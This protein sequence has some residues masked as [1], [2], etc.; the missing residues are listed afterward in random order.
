M[1]TAGTSKATAVVKDRAEDISFIGTTLGPLFLEDPST[2]SAEALFR[3]FSELDV[4]DAAKSWPFVEAGE[5]CKA[6][7]MM[8]NA[9]ADGLTDDLTWAFRQLFVGPMPK[10]AP[11]WGS[12]YTDFEQVIFGASTLELR[13]WMREHGIERHVDGH[14]PEDHIGEMLLLMAWLATNQPEDVEEFLRL[15]LLPWSGHFFE[16]VVRES[17][18]DFYRGLALLADASL[19]GIQEVLDIIVEYPHFYR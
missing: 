11:P 6:L 12:V 1:Q 9:L 4:D 8:K 15:H 14:T 5:A 2:G 19:N 7:Q 3:A 10:L 16:I 13:Q 18:H 17:P